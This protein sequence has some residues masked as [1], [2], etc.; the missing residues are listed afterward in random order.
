MLVPAELYV[1]HDTDEYTAFIRSTVSD[2][3]NILELNTYFN[4]WHNKNRRQL[5]S[6]FDEAPDK[7][8]HK[9]FIDWARKHFYLWAYNQEKKLVDDEINEMTKVIPES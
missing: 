2:P 6:L 5:H 4:E 9:N 7:E 3:K 1:I 8:N